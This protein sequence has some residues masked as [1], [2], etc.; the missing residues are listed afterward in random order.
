MERL[1][2]EDR[3]DRCVARDTRYAREAYDL[4]REALDHAQSLASEGDPRRQRGHMRG[5]QI[6]EGL[7]DL[8]L[9]RFGPLARLVMA[10]WG[11]TTTADVGE[12]VFNLIEVGVFSTDNND[13]REDFHGIYDFREALDQPFVPKSG[14]RS[15][16]LA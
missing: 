10:S 9:D 15:G 8:V 7:R 1:N 13:A 12:I 4:I 16:P 11:I 14:P 6:C 3:V 5:P 2:F